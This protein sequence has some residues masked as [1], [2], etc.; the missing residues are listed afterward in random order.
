MAIKLPMVW[1]ASDHLWGDAMETKLGQKYASEMS[2]ITV[3]EHSRERFK[4]TYVYII[5]ITS[6]PEVYVI[7][8]LIIWIYA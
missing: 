8:E 5:N 1:R 7:N 6:I 3:N 4:N 2:L